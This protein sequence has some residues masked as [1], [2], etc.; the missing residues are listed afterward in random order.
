[1][2][3]LGVAAGFAAVSAV[4]L[5]LVAYASNND[6]T[7]V[8]GPLF[9]LAQVMAIF[10]GFGVAAGFSGNLKCGLKNQ[11]RRV[12]A[13]HLV[14]ALGFSLLGMTLPISNDEKVW[15][16]YGILLNI[17]NNTALIIA[18]T[19]FAIG[20]ILWVSQLH[21]LLAGPTP[22]GD[23]HIPCPPNDSSDGNAS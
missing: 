5:W 8:G 2:G 22:H 21:K 16:D 19:G 4:F 17:M 10:G 1:M 12:G 15:S 23:K 3:V 20:T 14:S 11:L 13:L 6:Q 18:M 9:T 7:D